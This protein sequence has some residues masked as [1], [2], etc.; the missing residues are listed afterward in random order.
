MLYVNQS[1]NYFVRKRSNYIEPPKYYSNYTHDS[2]KQHSFNNQKTNHYIAVEDVIA[3]YGKSWL[4][5]DIPQVIVNKKHII[6]AKYLSI[7]DTYTH[8][9]LSQSSIVANIRDIY[10]GPI[11]END[12][13]AI[14]PYELDIYLPELKIAIEYNSN[15]YHTVN[16]VGSIYYHIK[17]SIRCRRVGIRLIHIY[18]FEDF[19]T[20]ISLLQD[21]ILG[22]DNYPKLDFNKNN[23]IDNIPKPSIVY[24]DSHYTIYGAGKLI[25]V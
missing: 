2:V 22:V 11:I 17:K 8:N 15:R 16:E 14:K 13:T 9:N 19:A 21:L 25:S 18:E 23:L 1:Y 6:N 24:N 3:K 4:N 12:R 5:L 7:I 20:Q 10:H